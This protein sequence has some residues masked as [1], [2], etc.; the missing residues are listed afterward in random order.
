MKDPKKVR[1][2]IESKWSNLIQK[3]K[4]ILNQSCFYRYPS[5][6]DPNKTLDQ[7]LLHRKE[8]KKIWLDKI[9][10]RN[11]IILRVTQYYPKLK[12]LN[13][14]SST[15][16]KRHKYHFFKVTL[17]LEWND[18]DIILGNRIKTRHPTKVFSIKEL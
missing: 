3:L 12:S 16:E 9:T 18:L 7:N 15:I 2:F 6:N 17:F 1:K 8:K 14:I 11:D 4:L 13:H 10:F 5:N